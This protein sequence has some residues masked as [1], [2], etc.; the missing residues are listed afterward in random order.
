MF[1]ANPS[2]KANSSEKAVNVSNTRYL[3]LKIISLAVLIFFRPSKSA[4]QFWCEACNGCSVVSYLGFFPAKRLIALLLSEVIS[5]KPS[6]I[7]SFLF[8]SFRKDNSL[9]RAWSLAIGRTYL[10]K[11][12]RLCSEHF[13][14]HCFHESNLMEVRIAFLTGE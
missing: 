2:L 1:K 7:P 6:R 3:V 4:N 12:S 11:D 10:P 8:S 9:R 13:E 14:D 5:Q